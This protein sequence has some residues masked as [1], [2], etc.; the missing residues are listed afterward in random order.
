MTIVLSVSVVCSFSPQELFLLGNGVSRSLP[1]LLVLVWYLRF[2][3]ILTQYQT[4]VGFSNK[5]NILYV[6]VIFLRH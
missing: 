5:I 4:L 6:M 2:D 3:K 1:C